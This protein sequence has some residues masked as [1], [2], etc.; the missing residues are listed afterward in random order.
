[1][2]LF[3]RKALGTYVEL[4]DGIVCRHVRQW[5]KSDGERE[6]KHLIRYIGPQIH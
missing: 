2:A 3:T 1:M 4:Q 6:V 5:L